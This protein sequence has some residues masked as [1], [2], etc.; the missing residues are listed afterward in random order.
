MIDRGLSV[1]V[2]NPIL[3]TQ[4]FYSSESKSAQLFLSI[5][6]HGGEEIKYS[7][8]RQLTEYFLENDVKKHL[9]Y[10]RFQVRTIR[11]LKSEKIYENLLPNPGPAQY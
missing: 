6:Y 5:C 11:P 8:C 1:A 2:S 9:K 3:S 7:R 4:D 10:R